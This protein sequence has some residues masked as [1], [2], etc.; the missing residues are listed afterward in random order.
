MHEAHSFTAF[1]GPLWSFS[2]LV[3]HLFDVLM[4]GYL[5]CSLLGDVTHVPAAGFNLFH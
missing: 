5:V 2:P 1:Q 4:S 3:A